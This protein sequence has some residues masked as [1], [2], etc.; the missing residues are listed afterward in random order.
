MDGRM[1]GW[2][3]L[4]MVPS[5]SLD[6]GTFLKGNSVKFHCSAYRPLRGLIFYLGKL[7]NG[8]V[9]TPLLSNVAYQTSIL[10]LHNVTSA[11][12]GSYACWYQL[13]RDGHRYNS[14]ISQTVGIT[15]GD[16][17]PKPSIKQSR[18]G[19]VYLPGET[20]RLHCFSPY[21]HPF[22]V[23]VLHEAGEENVVSQML[24]NRR[25]VVSFEVPLG[26]KTG[27]RNYTCSYTVQTAAGHFHSDVSDV[28][29][30]IV[31]DQIPPPRIG[32]KPSTDPT[33]LY[34]TLTCTSA[35]ALADS[36]FSL[37]K[38]DE[39]QPVSS[40]RTFGITANF[41]I[42][43][44]RSSNR[45]YYSCQHQV[46]LGTQL[47]NS[48]HS[49]R[50]NVTLAGDTAL[51]L[52]N[53]ANNCSGRVEV[54][55]EGV[56]GTVCN[57]SWD[58]KDGTVVCRH[59]GCGFVQSVPGILTYGRGSGPIWLKNV[60]CVGTESSLWLCSLD[61][62]YRWSSCQ[63][64][65][66]AAVQCTERPERPYFEL[67]GSAGLFLRDQDVSFVCSAP[68]Y[69]SGKRFQ[70]HKDGE[71][72]DMSQVTAAES[73]HS[74][75]FTIVNASEASGGLYSCGYQVQQAGL[76]YNSSRSSDVNVTIVDQLPKPGISLNK[77]ILLPSESVE[78][79]C[80]PPSY[81]PSLTSSSESP[82][83][84]SLR[85]SPIEERAEI[86]LSPSWTSGQWAS[87]FS[88]VTTESK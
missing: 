85:P 83:R 71:L 10:T 22:S 73:T 40:F 81:F 50:L 77:E 4:P 63:H 41:R 29:H 23:F 53:G 25:T 24:P 36:T 58:A 34:I 8:S 45:G 57:H 46:R 47:F 54:F 9:G 60:A 74:V 49:D 7:V 21:S 87:T 33:I 66:D 43:K 62:T 2:M 75:T 14:S 56:W 15:V 5:L 28:L 12:G 70:L 84:T 88:A 35:S 20:A 26:M 19:N 16:H 11:D 52:A 13:I 3:A 65:K 51:R 17:P 31:T 86:L 38:E 61:S 64:H 1:D 27:Y 79:R 72:A 67:S 39:G 76:L 78:V 18:Q 48:T 42:S 82:R 6:R 30:L 32:I 59:L 55:H 68:S 37:Y 80:I 44:M 69:I